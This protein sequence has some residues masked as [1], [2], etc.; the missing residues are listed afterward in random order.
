MHEHGIVVLGQDPVRS[1]DPTGLHRRDQDI[2]QRAGDDRLRPCCCGGS[3]ERIKLGCQDAAP[4]RIQLRDHHLRL[5]R[6]EC[7][8]QDVAPLRHVG[9]VHG[10]PDRV[11]QRTKVLVEG[12]HR[13][14]LHQVDA[15]ERD[16]PGRHT[17]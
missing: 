3:E 14:Q 2:A 6:R 10:P 9:G 13:R 16:Q 12:P 11:A 4:E 15:V 5:R 1:L 7:G 17:A 8:Q